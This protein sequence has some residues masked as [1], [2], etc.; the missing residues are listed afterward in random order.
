MAIIGIILLIGIV[1]KNAIMMIDFAL[2]AERKRGHQPER[3]DPPGLPAALPPDHD[4]DDVRADRRVAAGAGQRRR[5]RAAPPAR[6]RH[7]RR[8]DRFAVPDALHD[9]GDLPLSRPHRPSAFG[10]RP[11]RSA[12]AGG[13]SGLTRASVAVGRRPAGA[14]AEAAVSARGILSPPTPWATGENAAKGGFT[15]LPNDRRSQGSFS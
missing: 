8:A 5:V 10:R 15:E 4:D 11:Q 6:H 12:R 9:A 13:S 1:K 2:E 3:G 7:R 14:R